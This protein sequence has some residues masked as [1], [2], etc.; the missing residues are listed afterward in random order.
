M[1]ICPQCNGEFV[2]AGAD[3]AVCPACAAPGGRLTPLTL[4]PGVKE[5]SGPPV[6]LWVVLAFLGLFVAAVLAAETGAVT[7]ETH[8]TKWTAEGKHEAEFSGGSR[9]RPGPLFG[10]RF[11]PSVTVTVPRGTGHDL[12]TRA[13]AVIK[14]AGAGGG[15]GPSSLDITITQVMPEGADWVP[16][17][18]SGKC[19]FAATYAIKAETPWSSFVARGQVS[20]QV[21]QSMRGFCSRDLYQEKMSEAV[22][23]SILSHIDTLVGKY[24]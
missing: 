15:P 12:A 7:S 9:G 14:K 20:G 19:T 18:K 22:A 3:G 11:S 21:T 10:V 16:F 4:P 23:A 1:A 24:S 8:E 5:R 2:P 6:V 17:S 13:A